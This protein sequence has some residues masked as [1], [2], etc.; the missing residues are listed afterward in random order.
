MLKV[1][2]LLASK[3]ELK[4]RLINGFAWSIGGAVVSRGFTLAASIIVSRSIGAEGF[5]ELGI[6]NSTVNMLGEMAGLGIGLAATKFLSQYRENDPAKASRILSLNAIMTLLMSLTMGLMLYVFSSDVAIH[7]FNNERLSV[8][9]EIAS[10]TLFFSALNGGIVGALAGFEAFRHIA[11]LNFIVGIT[12]FVLQFSLVFEYGLKGV[13]I[14]LL[15]SQVINF[16]IGLIFLKYN[17]RN[18]GI[19][20]TSEELSSEV[21]KILMFNFPALL[22]AL[23]VI[24]V[25]WGVNVLLVNQQNGFVEMGFFNAANQ[26][27]MALLFI[28]TAL[29]NVILPILSSIAGGG[30]AERYKKIFYYNILLNFFMAISMIFGVLLLSDIIMSSYGEAFSDQSMVLNVLI[31]VAGLMAVNNVI[32]HAISSLNKMWTGFAFNLM[33][34]AAMAVSAYILCPEYGAL[35]LA[36]ANLI[37]YGLHTVWQFTYVRYNIDKIVV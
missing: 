2:K 24:P 33:W 31:I 36:M 9:L 5:G 10:V 32:G 37:A 4:K 35:G 21:H 22:A 18:T 6:L 13:V 11:K 34:A 26:W 8:L 23:M 3:S 19:V 30:D 27:K 29:G 20:F 12:S 28:P 25:N 7:L 15:L 14:A 1:K 17:M 16:I